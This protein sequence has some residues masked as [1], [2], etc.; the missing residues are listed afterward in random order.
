VKS[1]EF[2]QKKENF[3]KNKNKYLQKKEISPMTPLGFH[4]KVYVV[5]YSSVKVF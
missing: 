5:K 1:S 4:T 3:S 2:Y